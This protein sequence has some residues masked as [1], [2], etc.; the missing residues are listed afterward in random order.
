MLRC[1]VNVQH[2]M[3]RV[4]R[5]DQRKA[6]LA[7]FDMRIVMRVRSGDVNPRQINADVRHVLTVAE[8]GRETR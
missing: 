1:A 5:E 8:E 7:H 6:M 2:R 3:V 4:W